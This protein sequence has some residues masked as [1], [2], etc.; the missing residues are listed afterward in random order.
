MQ[1]AWPLAIEHMS[2]DITHDCVGYLSTLS[3]LLGTSCVET[4]VSIL[5]IKGLSGH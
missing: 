4:L 3:L 2:G 5:G 1:I